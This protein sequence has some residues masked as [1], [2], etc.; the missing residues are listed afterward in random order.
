[1]WLRL[2]LRS[3]STGD[4]VA[5]SGLLLR[6]SRMFSPK[7]FETREQTDDI[8]NWVISQLSHILRHSTADVSFL[9]ALFSLY[10]GLNG[11]KFLSSRTADQ[12]KMERCL[13][14]CV[15]DV[16]LLSFCC[17]CACEWFADIRLQ[18][19]LMFEWLC[20]WTVVWVCDLNLLFLLLQCNFLCNISADC[21]CIS[22]TWRE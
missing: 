8:I 13:W 20:V 15:V 5:L 10:V 17:V 16:S 7:T 14:L 22:I 2:T 12:F 3:T 18:A 1:M 11:Y 6:A 19:A 9:S 21:W 4:V